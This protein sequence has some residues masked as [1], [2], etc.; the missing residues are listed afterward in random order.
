M[1]RIEA[2]LNKCARAYYAGDPIISDE[3]FDRL[4][5]SVGYN[6]VGAKQ[7]EHIE[8]HF[9]KLY[10]LQKFYEDEGK[11]SPLRGY[12]HIDMSP[13]L[14]GAAISVLYIDGELA[15]V[16]TRGDGVE[17]TVVTD[18]FIDSAFIPKTIPLEGAVQIVGEICAPKY[19]ENARNFAAGSLNL[20]DSNEFK[21][22]PLTFFA[23]GIQPNQCG[24]FHQDM[25]RLKGWGFNT[26]KDQDIQHVYPCDGMVYRLDNYSEFYAA[27]YTSKHPQGAYALDRKSVV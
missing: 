5:E 19:I 27:G 4:A 10:S 24:M 15:R 3:V 14:D 2:Y 25:V 17:G 1:N 9:F 6:K 8:K 12:K 7:H 18:K 11:E 26:I 21:T 16:L 13:K 23:Y 20:N 22:R